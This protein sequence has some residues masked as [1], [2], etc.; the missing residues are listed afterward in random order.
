MS[1][2]GPLLAAAGSTT[3]LVREG[4][5]RQR[6]IRLR[7]GGHMRL[8]EPHA[9]G[10]SAGGHHALLAWQVEGGSRSDPPTGWRTFLLSEISEV[11]LTVR[12]FIAQPTYH[13]EK[14]K[15]REIEL[16]VTRP[17]A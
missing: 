3:E 5:R 6:S 9:I 2:A 16:E 12:G 13:P 15:L 4:I 10:I 11:T 8:V 17:P 1:A 7:Y 14:A